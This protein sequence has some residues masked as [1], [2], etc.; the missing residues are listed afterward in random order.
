MDIRQAIHSRPMRWQQIAVVGI[1]IMLTMI[2]GYEIIVMPFVMP[3]LAKA[4]MLSPVEVGY[5][6]S[7]SVLGMAVGA[8]VISPLAD[9]I[10]RRSHILLCLL[11]ISG[12]MLLSARS[13]KLIELILFRAFAGLF[14]GGVISSI[15]VLVSEYSSEKRRGV[16][17]GLY[18]IGL[19][20]GSAL[21]GSAIAPLVAHYGWRGPLAFGGLLTLAMMA[22]VFPLLPESVYYLIERRPK[23]ALEKYNKIAARL[24]Y[25]RASALPAPSR[26][27]DGP[28]IA[29]AVRAIFGGAMLRRTAYLWLGYAGLIAAFYFA[30][31]WTAKLIADVSGSP[32]LGIRVGMLIMIGGV[33]GALV[34]AALSLKLRPLL[35]TALIL[36]GGAVVYTLY[37]SHFKNLDL[38][39]PLSVLVGLVASGG[40]AAFYAVS[41]QMYPAIVRGTAVGLMI[42]FGRAVSV[43]V[44]VWTGYMLT[45]GW[46]P[47]LLYRLFGGVL[48]LAAVFILLLHR[49]YKADASALDPVGVAGR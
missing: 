48:A 42:G 37:A 4:W 8:V 20:L 33:A 28:A 31:T 36:L 24:G 41:P 49:S 38:A 32:A 14:I 46:T 40:V 18:G 29:V 11:M 3:H 7:A 16:V 34:F 23:H 47:S 35:V 12:G 27:D 1:C 13:E 6:L 5:L 43:F 25:P 45:L 39:V 30:N 22:I 44:P 10:G 26:R 17:M 19:P 21:A 15:N 2:D 9:R